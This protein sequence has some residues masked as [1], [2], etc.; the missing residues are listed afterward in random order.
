MTPAFWCILIIIFF[1]YLLAGIGGWLTIKQTG[2]FDINQPR[3]QAR[4]LT[5]AAARVKA[6][7]ANGWEVTVVFACCVF[8]AHF[9][10]VPETE[11]TLPAS[12]FVV[13]RFLYMVCYACKLSPWRTIIFLVGL[14]ACF[15]LIKLAV[16]YSA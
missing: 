8:I 6:A 1:N 14:A 7:Q 12:V 16:T 13:S 2:K 10:G 4:E 9:A 15:W 3:V 5:G 11:A